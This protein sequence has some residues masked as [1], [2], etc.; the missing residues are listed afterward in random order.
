MPD[1]QPNLYTHAYG[2]S[3]LLSEEILVANNL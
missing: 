2:H 3:D 1:G